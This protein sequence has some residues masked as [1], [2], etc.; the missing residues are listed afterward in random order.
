MDMTE[1]A[2]FLEYKADPAPERLTALLAAIQDRLYNICFQI[3][4]RPEDAEDAC[5]EVLIE[6]TRGLA[7]VDEPRPFKVWL[8]RVAVHTALDRK[9]SLD[10]QA[11]LKRQASV[12]K[13]EG[14]PM[15]ETERA[16]LMRAIRTL[17]DRTR[18]MVLEHYFDKATLE[19]IGAREGISGVA[20]F[21]RLDRARETLR[22]A[23]L[24]AGFTVASASVAQ[25]LESVTPVVAPAGFIGKAALIAAGGAVVGT[26][27]AV[28]FGTLVSALL[29]VGAAS[30][31]GYLVGK[32]RGNARVRELQDRIALVERPAPSSVNPTRIPSAPPVES[33]RVVDGEPPTGVESGA[34]PPEKRNKKGSDNKRV[35]TENPALVYYGRPTPIDPKSLQEAETWDE[36]YK[37]AKERRIR[38][39]LLEDAI[40]H[41]LGRELNLEAATLASLQKIFDKEREETTRTVVESMGG[42]ATFRQKMDEQGLN[43][44]L[45][46][47][48]WGRL[49]Q[50]VR[51][52]FND[53]YLKHLSYDQLTLLDEQLR[54]E[55][56]GLESSY[57]NEGTFYLIGGVGKTVK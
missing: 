4:R 57:S 18:C 48:E 51:Q 49:R 12:S 15:N 37:Q 56:I 53:E 10:R 47:V 17:D 52:A 30:T 33:P 40:F 11:R 35:E 43:W 14:P 25:S 32:N 26:K 16:E 7:S 36:F 31:G 23:L 34:S 13:P 28:T 41:R 1:E 50:N 2:A 27:T 39:R 6:V 29:L 45:L 24:G 20:V 42:P 46:N 21:K 44:N 3:L 9:D 55:Q 22:R 5:Q 8:Y 19:E 54:N 38:G